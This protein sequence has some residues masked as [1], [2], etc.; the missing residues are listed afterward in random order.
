MINYMISTMYFN[1]CRNSV[2]SVKMQTVTI[3]RCY[4]WVGPCL[5]AFTIPHKELK[6]SKK[7]IFLKDKNI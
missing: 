6:N 3:Y 2:S 4:N 5:K 1:F 7:Y